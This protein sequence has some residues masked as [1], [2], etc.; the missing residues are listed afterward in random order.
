MALYPAAVL[1]LIPHDPAMDPHILPRVA[2]LHV[3][4]GGATGAGLASYFTN[5]SG[6]IES[7]FSIDYD[8]TVTQFRDTYWQADANVLANN[9]AVSIE[10]QGK[11]DGS[12]TEAQ[13]ASIKALLTWLH[14]THNIPLVK[15]PTWFGY[16]VGYHI[17][18]M[19]EWA[20]GP[21]SCPGPLRI[22]QFYDVI[23][24]WMAGASNPPASAIPNLPSK[25]IPKVI[26]TVTRSILSVDGD[27]GPATIRQWQK[28]MGTVV[29][30]VISRP[31][32]LIRAVQKRCG[33]TVDG[34]LGPNTWRAIQRRLG[35]SADGVPGPLTVKALQR[36]LNS[37]QF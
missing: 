29:D 33:A 4:A 23:V 8:G 17:L 16:G 32:S 19:Q 20:G 7:H 34:Y 24:P 25:V 9:F 5:R 18:F 1:R 14:K 3:D 10:T 21:R 26:Q 28:V 11:A 2:I 37:I 36:K 22:A 35:V 13:L 30:G 15:C 6:G 31:S 27:L 12:W